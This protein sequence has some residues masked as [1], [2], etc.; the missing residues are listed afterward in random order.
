MKNLRPAGGRKVVQLEPSDSESSDIPLPQ[1]KRPAG[2]NKVVQLEPSDSESS[3]IQ[4]EVTEEEKVFAQMSFP[5]CEDYA[6]R[7]D[8]KKVIQWL[9]EAASKR[10]ACYKRRDIIV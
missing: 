10:I 5:F 3:D 7:E 9:K 4:L 6:K 2:G 1:N 8:G